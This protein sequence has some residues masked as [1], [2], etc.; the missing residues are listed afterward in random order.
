ML[1]R[2]RAGRRAAPSQGLA[3]ALRAAAVPRSLGLSQRPLSC[4]LRG[5]LAFSLKTRT[6][7]P[8]RVLNEGQ[9]SREG[10]WRGAGHC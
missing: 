2:E 4:S 6:M 7:G 8:R 1:G 5:A 3:R 10:G 9:N